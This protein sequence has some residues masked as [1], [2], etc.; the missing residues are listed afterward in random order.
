MFVNSHLR[1]SCFT[2]RSPYLS[3]CRLPFFF[4]VASPRAENNCPLYLRGVVKKYGERTHYSLNYETDNRIRCTLQ[5]K[6]AFR[7]FVNA[8]VHS[9]TDQ[10]GQLGKQK[11]RRA[12]FLMHK[13]LVISLSILNRSLVCLPWVAIL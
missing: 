3:H 8:L 12:S 4:P 11:N 10:S 1:P 5:S 9:Y 13:S 7:S 6:C 2:Y